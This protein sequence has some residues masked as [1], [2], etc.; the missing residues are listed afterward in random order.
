MPSA[1]LQ[2]HYNSITWDYPAPCG[3][4]GP[5]GEHH[6]LTLVWTLIAGKVHICALLF[7]TP[8]GA[9]EVAI[10]DTLKPKLIARALIATDLMVGRVVPA[11]RSEPF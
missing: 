3:N 9:A 7:Q 6:Q 2:I 11:S 1:T 10:T 8:N 5:C 4:C